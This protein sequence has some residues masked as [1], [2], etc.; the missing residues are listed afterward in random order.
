MF[1][2]SDKNKQ[3][4]WNTKF[5]PHFCPKTSVPPPPHSP[6][7]ATASARSRIYSVSI[8]LVFIGNARIRL[9]SSFARS[10]LPFFSDSSIR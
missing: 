2:Q 3:N 10:R 8:V 1:N 5:P 6:K 4:F 9:A 7:K